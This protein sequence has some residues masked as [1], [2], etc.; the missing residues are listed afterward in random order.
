[1]LDG[2]LSLVE[3]TGFENR[4]MGNCTGGSNPSPSALKERALADAASALFLF[5]GQNLGASLVAEVVKTFEMSGETKLLTSSATRL[6][7]A[8]R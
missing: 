3:G 1:M 7:I 4:R 6:E 8:I 5:F 2:W